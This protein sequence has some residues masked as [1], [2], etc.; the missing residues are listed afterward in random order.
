MSD[1]Q[2]PTSQTTLERAKE[3]QRKLLDQVG[4]GRGPCNGAGIGQVRGKMGIRGLLERQ[5]DIPLPDEIDGFPVEWI[6]VG[7]ITAGGQS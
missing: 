4:F 5:T 7:T 1:D 3:A 2:N 6:V